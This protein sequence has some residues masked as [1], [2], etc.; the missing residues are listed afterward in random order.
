[1]ATSPA[2]RL[3]LW[4]PAPLARSHA[5]VQLT[6][7]VLELVHATWVSTEVADSTEVVTPCC[8]YNKIPQLMDPRWLLLNMPATRLGLWVAAQPEAGFL[9]QLAQV[10]R[11]LS[12][13]TAQVA[14]PAYA[15]FL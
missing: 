11:T 2:T 3:G 10:V 15:L 1:M 12:E 5:M 8:C 6:H 9:V 4:R 14:A 7:L 13:V